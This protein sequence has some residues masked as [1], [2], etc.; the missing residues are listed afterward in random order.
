MGLSKAQN[1]S[2]SLSSKAAP[3]A[4]DSR[5]GLLLR[6]L[7]SSV[8][9]TFRNTL[10]ILQEMQIL[11][12]TKTWTSLPYTMTNLGLDGQLITRPS[13]VPNTFDDTITI[14]GDKID[15]ISYIKDDRRGDACSAS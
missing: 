9:L 2:H 3:R 7:R 1:Y 4:S 11:R 8:L 12:A 5:S 10:R 13:S 14:R 6:P 15:N